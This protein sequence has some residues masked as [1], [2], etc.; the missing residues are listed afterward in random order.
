LIVLY[1][2]NKITIDGSTDIT[3]TE[4]VLGRF[5]SYGWHTSRVENGDSDV[6]SISAAIEA[7]LAVSLSFF[8]SLCVS[9][10]LC[11]VAHT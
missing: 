4:D 3:F 11:Q 2:D 6:D 9:L 10:S 1:D 5:Q 8:L 7:A